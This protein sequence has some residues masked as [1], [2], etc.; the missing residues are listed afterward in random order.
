[1][2]VEVFEVIDWDEVVEEVVVVVFKVVES[3]FGVVVY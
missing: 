1:M 2:L 3:G